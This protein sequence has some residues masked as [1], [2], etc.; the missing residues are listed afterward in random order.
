MRS[1]EDAVLGL[2]RNLEN[3]SRLWLDPSQSIPKRY[4]TIGEA[5]TYLGMSPRTVRSLLSRRLLPYAKIGH[6][7]VRIDVRK[8]DKLTDMWTIKSLFDNRFGP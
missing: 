2:S 1:M 7:T 8:L 3:I 5:A 6:R 4:V